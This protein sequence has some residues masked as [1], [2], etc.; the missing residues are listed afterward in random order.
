[1]V[2]LAVA[3][4]VFGQNIKGHYVA[5]T[6]ADGTIYHTLPSTLF[7]NRKC[8][9]LIFDITYKSNADGRAVI[10]FTYEMEATCPADSV[11][12]VSGPTRMSG[13][14]KKLYISSEKKAWKHRYTFS[15]DV[16]SLYV[17]FDPAAT[18]S[19]TLYAQGQAF[20]YPVKASAWKDYALVGNKIFQMVRM[21]EAH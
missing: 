1:M 10:N 16:K 4:Q 20:V 8:G 3:G 21:N 12:F 6:E 9:D 18:P 14:T 5:K 15:V 11:C 17:F 19:V 7:E 2:C 13:A